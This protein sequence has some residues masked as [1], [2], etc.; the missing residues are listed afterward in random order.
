MRNS[1]KLPLPAGQVA[2]ISELS[3]LESLA[4]YYYDQELPPLD[5]LVNLRCLDWTSS[6]DSEEISKLVSLRKLDCGAYGPVGFGSWG[7]LNVSHIVELPHLEEVYC[8]YCRVRNVDQFEK[9]GS[10]RKLD[11]RGVILVKK[12]SPGSFLSFFPKMSTLQ[13]LSVGSHTSYTMPGE[14]DGT[15]FEGDLERL[16][17][18]AGLRFLRVNRDVDSIEPL[19]HLKNL[20][21][22]HVGRVN[23]DLA[24]LAGCESLMEFNLI[25]QR[26]Q[27]YS[28][29]NDTNIKELFGKVADDDFDSFKKNQSEWLENLLKVDAFLEVRE[30]DDWKFEKGSR[31]YSRPAKK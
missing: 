31:L 2:F 13:E 25:L 6:A 3:Q 16:R 29:V 22:L 9:C 11:A 21:R 12:P 1:G 14:P 15:Q 7:F 20:E 19:S 18:F 5:K 10:L 28:A 17:G 4:F 26:K 30:D 27:D 24:P 23:G 8:R